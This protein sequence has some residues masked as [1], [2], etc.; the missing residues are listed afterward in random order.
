MEK[1]TKIYIWLIIIL[2]ATNL[3]TIASVLYHIY[4]EKATTPVQNAEMPNEQR[5]RFLVDQLNLDM[6]Q[7]GQFREMNRTFNRTANPITRN[8]ESLRLQMLEEMAQATPDT[9]KL[10]TITREIGDLHRELKNATVEFY[11][12]MKTICNEEQQT[13]LYQ[14]F[15]SML[16][17]E[18]DV[19]LPRGRHQGGRGRNINNH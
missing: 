16:N 17:Q 15:H 14:I 1:R 19:K 12:R 9:A 18:E 2:L 7:A 8:L 5:T 6:Q 3:A 10:E 13:K 11:I 4:A